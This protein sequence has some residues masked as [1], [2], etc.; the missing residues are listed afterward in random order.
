MIVHFEGNSSLNSDCEINEEI[1]N[2]EKE[3]NFTSRAPNFSLENEVTHNRSISLVQ[4]IE[5]DQVFFGE[6]V[7][8]QVFFFYY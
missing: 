4:K 6:D 8:E 2:K 1:K 5:K 7:S 3:E